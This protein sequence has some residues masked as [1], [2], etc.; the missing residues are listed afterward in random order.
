M[1][2]LY[3]IGDVDER[4]RSP[5]NRAVLARILSAALL[6]VEAVLVRVEVDVASGLPAFMTVGLPDSAVRESRERVRTS[7][8]NGGGPVSPPPPAGKP[9]PAR[10][11][12]GGAGVR[13]PPPPRPP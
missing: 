7:I 13:P 2:G 3:R 5:K 9:P 12:P 10:P 4:R 6:G 8:P 1:L 11:P